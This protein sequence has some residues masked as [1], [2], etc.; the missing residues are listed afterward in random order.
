MTPE[1][2]NY[3]LVISGVVLTAFIK[4]II[5]RVHEMTIKH[6]KL[7]DDHY[8]LRTEL[9]THYVSKIDFQYVLDNIFSQLSRIEDKIDNKLDKKQ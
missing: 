8:D 7:R 4:I 2:L 9:N 3:I 6:D 5:S 1:L